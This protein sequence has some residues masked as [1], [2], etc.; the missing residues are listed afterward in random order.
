MTLQ[1]THQLHLVIIGA[2]LAGLAAAITTAMEG[3]RATLLEKVTELKEVGAGLQ[4]TPNATRLLKYWGVYD[5]LEPSAAVPNSLTVRRFDG[6][7]VLA[8]EPRF[9]ETIMQRYGAPFWDLHRVDLQRAL[10]SRA[11]ALGVQVRLGADVIDVDFA[12]RT[13][14]LASGE[15]VEGDVIMCADGL[16]SNLR[17]KF[18]GKPTPPL[19][20]GDLAYRIVLHK[21]QVKDPELKAWVQ[22]PTVN[23]WPG[24]HAH[25]VA[26]SIRGGELFNI[27]L[28]CPDDLPDNVN[29]A[30][31]DIEQ[32]KQLFK[33]NELEQWT[34]LTC[35][36]VMGGDACH[37]MLP[38][39]AQGANSSLEDGAVLGKLLGHVRKHEDIPKAL[40]LYQQERKSRGEAVVRETFKQ[41]DSFH[42]PDGEEQRKRD[43]VFLDSLGGELPPNFPSRWYVDILHTD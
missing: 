32:M 15:R 2:G 12:S 40:D 9:R 23:F 5:E 25:A 39:L 38:Y 3:H 17:S 30:S 37:P 8:H 10:A 20:T 1:E 43:K 33:V 31:G 34:S 22:Q 19:P 29:K 26:Y 35:N 14:V 36:F 4:V 42:M 18:L 27:V 24:P 13:V 21:D 28:L 41:R 7:R 6:T 11:K 16:W